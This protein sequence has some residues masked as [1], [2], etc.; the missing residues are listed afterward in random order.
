MGR[1]SSFNDDDDTAAGDDDAIDPNSLSQSPTALPRSPRRDPRSRQSA[2]LKATAVASVGGFDETVSSVPRIR[3]SGAELQPGQHLGRYRLIERLGAGAMGVVWA[4]KDPNLDRRVAIK[5]VHSRHIE[6]DDA[7]GRFLREARAMAKVSDRSV[8]A[9]FDADQA[10]DR[11]FIAMELIDGEPLGDLLRKRRP[12]EVRDWRKWL[13]IMLFAGRGLE[14]AHKAGVLHRDFK[15]DNILVEANGRVCVSDFG[16]ADL[17]TSPASRASNVNIGLAAQLSDVDLT[18]TGAL[19]GTPVYMSPE[20]LRGGAI[21]ARADQFSFCVAAYEALYGERPF[22]IDVDRQYPAAPQ[23]IKAIVDHQIRPVPK[24]SRVPTRVRQALLRGLSA[25]PADRWP[26]MT[27]LVEELRLAMPSR[28]PR[29][30]IALGGVTVLTAI[31]VAVIALQSKPLPVNV[32]P[33][34]PSTVATVE[35]ERYSGRLI[36]ELPH[37]IRLAI[38]PSGDR[39][40]MSTP[41]AIWLL[42]INAN[43]LTKK[44]QANRTWFTILSFIDDETLLLAPSAPLRIQR[45]QIPQDVLADLPVPK[46]AI[47]W[48]GQLQAGAL[49]D[50]SVAS[51]SSELYV[52]DQPTMRW[53]IDERIEHLSISPDRKRFAYLTSILLVVIDVAQGTTRTLPVT[54][55]TALAWNGNDEIWYACGTTVHPS[56]YQ[57]HFDQGG[58]APPSLI[59]QKPTGWIGQILIA[60]KRQFMIYNDPFFVPTLA[61]TDRQRDDTTS[62]EWTG[63]FLNWLD[64]GELLAWDSK[65]HHVYRVAGKQR[66]DTGIV[67]EGYP[68]NATR[69]G[70]T[71]VVATRLEGRREITA[72]SISSGKQLWSI[73]S[74]IALAVRC[75]DD[76][77]SPCFVIEDM[78]MDKDKRNTISGIDTNT[79]NIIHGDIRLPE[80][81]DIA[82][83]TD[84][85]RIA[86]ATMSNSVVEYSVTGELRRSIK[87]EISRIRTI[88]YAGPTSWYV[89]GAATNSVHSIQLVEAEGISRPFRLGAPATVIS[90]LRPAPDQKQLAYVLRKF[91]PRLY[92]LSLTR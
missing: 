82:V 91:D 13:R 25:Q 22:H 71:L 54:E 4:A 40:A 52:E 23:L 17:S 59:F 90:I 67:L 73:N 64:N 20:Q 38:A 10:H 32:A 78:E 37:P 21:T 48:F 42:D 33:R 47:R 15:P 9:V 18:V 88:A 56:I 14:A 31:I 43:K 8:V 7:A 12:E 65:D 69:N 41:D 19:M 29:V 36:L 28:K 81:A 16:L 84:G 5:V 30:F 89:G 1:D 51:S 68:A 62:P 58:F 75:A 34:L 74:G 50:G 45:W 39:L 44:S 79:G 63:G 6:N 35:G 53:S 61:S 27:S 24:G 11:L 55:G 76:R 86:I 2:A 72:Y 85:E 26:D 60:N 49:L 66:S 87:S 83:S 80:V 92:A 46:G 70:T 57:T 77:M 3:S